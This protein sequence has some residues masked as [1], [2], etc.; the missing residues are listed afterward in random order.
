MDINKRFDKNM[1]TVK[2]IG[3]TLGFKLYGVDPT[4]QV[5]T[6]PYIGITDMY[7]GMSN[8]SDTVMGT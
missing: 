8:I 6:D 3:K 1:E 5:Y 4:W 7:R 2:L